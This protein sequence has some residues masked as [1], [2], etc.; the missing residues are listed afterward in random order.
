[1]VGKIR[2]SAKKRFYQRR[3]VT[4]RAETRRVCVNGPLVHCSNLF[5][6]RWCSGCP[7]APVLVRTSPQV[8]AIPAGSAARLLCQGQGRPRPEVTW[9]KDGVELVPGLY[10][11]H[12]IR[13]RSDAGTPEF[14][15][16]SIWR[17]GSQDNY[18]A[19]NS[20]PRD[21]DVIYMNVHLVCRSKTCC[22]ELILYF[23]RCARVG[24]LLT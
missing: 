21:I 6:R 5:N 3:A 9:L 2:V 8:V 22:Q 17:I 14:Q 1:M 12:L 24:F 13:G 15:S 23:R 7:V 11:V 19:H 10:C 20:I 16:T 4:R 18:I